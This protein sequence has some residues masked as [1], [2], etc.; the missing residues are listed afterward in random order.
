[1]TVLVTGGSGIVG[2]S[3]ISHLLDR[4]ETVI[5]LCRNPK[6]KNSAYLRW[7][8]GDVGKERL[9]LDKEVWERI[10]REIDTIFHLA[11]RTDFKG[12]SLEEYSAVNIEGVCHIKQLALQSGAWLH[13][14]STA[15]VCGDWKGAFGEHQMQQEQRFHNFYEESKA[16]GEAVL[17]EEP[18]PDY[19]IYRP[20]I[21]LE[22]NPTAASTS[23]FGP[24][25][26]LD[27]VF[28][29][30]LGSV[31]R[32]LD[33]AT[34]RVAGNAQAH[35]PFVFDDDV[36]AVLADLSLNHAEN[37]KTYHL[38]PQD[39]L[40]NAILEQ[41]FNQAFSR[42]AVVWVAGDVLAEEE[43]TTSER[44]LAKKT[45]MYTPYL[46]LHT[47]F[48]RKNLE[49]ALGDDV[50]PPITEEALLATFSTFLAS[51]KELKK[52]VSYDEKFHLDTYFN[53]FLVKH[54]GKPLIKNLSSLSASFHVEIKGYTTWQI[55]IE[56]GVL[57]VIDQGGHGDFGYSTDGKSFLKIASG[58]LSP[59]RG[60]FQGAIQ[61]ENNP[62]EALRTATALEEFF[63]QY[64]YNPKSLE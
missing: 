50:L 5:A 12:K 44:I 63:Y 18:A 57:T 21:I 14:V 43:L 64:P 58:K 31:K 59:Q 54:S 17:R 10:S 47:F 1:M 33:M 3:L 34:I 25:V 42:K 52:V 49:D 24:L 9:G 36:A 15:F 46:S 6:E 27:G 22:R 8:A 38:V 39:S 55:I 20:S 29:I 13:H 60:F 41:V 53:H 19:T 2:R 37:R 35:L 11:A 16:L 7:V 30:C 32:N 61:L 48:L 4:G 62:K 28:R 40:K 45:R 56:K 26:F 51:K 23:V